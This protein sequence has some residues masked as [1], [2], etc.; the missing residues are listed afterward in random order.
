MVVKRTAPGPT[1]QWISETADLRADYRRA[2]GREPGPLVGIGVSS[3]SDD[4]AT[5]ADARLSDLVISAP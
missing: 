5:M 2:F 4:T 1:G 3:D